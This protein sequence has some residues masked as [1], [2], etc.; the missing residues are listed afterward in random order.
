MARTVNVPVFVTMAI[1]PALS[2][3]RSADYT[4]IT[5]VGADPEGIWYVMEAENF[6]GAPDE[7]IARS[8]RH[9]QIYK[10]TIIS[11]E[12]VAAQILYRPLLVPALLNAGLRPKIYE[13]RSP[14]WRSKAQRIES[15]QPLFKQKRIFVREGLEDLLEQLDRYPEI[16][17]DDLLDSL[18]QHLEIS[19]PVRVGEI[20]PSLGKDWFERFTGRGGWTYEPPKADDPSVLPNKI[21][22]DG[23]WTGHHATASTQELSDLLDRL[24][25][26]G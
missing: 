26:R 4:G 16:E 17:H 23:T 10:P 12:A 5:V 24:R 1:D 21:P 9:A 22:T 18:S 19:R 25:S 13:Y 3:D 11:L 20:H 15:L 2:A 14:P 7:V 6:K 8:V